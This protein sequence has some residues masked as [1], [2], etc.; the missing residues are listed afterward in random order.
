[1]RLFQKFGVDLGKVTCDLEDAYANP[2]LEREFANDVSRAESI[3]KLKQLGL[4][5]LK[6]ELIFL[7][8]ASTVI[9]SILP[10]LPGIVFSSTLIDASTLR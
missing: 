4:H 10:H 9:Y 2:R 7:L 5:I 8:M 3:S 6:H 1:M